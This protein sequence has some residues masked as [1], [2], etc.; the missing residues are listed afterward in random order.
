MAGF[1]IRRLFLAVPVV[2]GALTL[3]FVLFFVVPGDPAELL[4]GSAS[5]RNVPEATLRAVEERFDL[6]EPFLTQYGNYWGR[7]LTGDLGESYTTRRPV[8]DILGETFPNSLRLAIWAIIIETVIGI[9]AGVV[10]AVKRYSFID[11]LTTVGSALF[12]ALPVFVF[13][14]LLQQMFGVFP[15]QNDWPDWARLRVQGTPDEWALFIFP[16][17][18]GWR[19]LV[20]PAIALASVTT[21]LVT[22]MMRTT[23]IEVSRADYMRT[24]MA[25]GLTERQVVLR[26]GLRNALIPVVTLLGLDL[27]NMIGAA[28]LTET[29][30]GWN[31]MGSR[32]AGSIGR[33]DA[34]TVLGLTM[35][36]VIAYVVINLIVDLSYGYFDPR[37]RVGREAK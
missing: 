32:I 13:G 10:S 5:G 22:R 34:P 3:L 17:G 27:A 29:V 35:V 31:G 26:H 33:R 19:F 20:L 1:I 4:A 37:V 16:T 6:N 24:A 30:F 28:I 11:S 9:S 21:A 15:N 2:W 18:D 14:F 23:M 25:K 36:L 12:S 8:S 7:L